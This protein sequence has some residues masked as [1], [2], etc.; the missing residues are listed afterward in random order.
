MKSSFAEKASRVPGDTRLNSQERALAA[1]QAQSILGYMGRHAA[2]TGRAVILS[3]SLALK[4]PCSGQFCEYCVQFKIDMELLERVQ[5]RATKM[6]KTLE[7][8]SYKKR[9]NELGLLI[10][11]KAQGGSH[12]HVQKSESIMKR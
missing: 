8:L 2:S 10:L 6:M 5:Q 3:I 11:E 4:R 9:L 12:P 7:H 1:K